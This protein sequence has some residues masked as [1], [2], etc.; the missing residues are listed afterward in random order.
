MRPWSVITR[1]RPTQASRPCSSTQGIECRCRCK[2]RCVCDTARL[3]LDL[4]LSDPPRLQHVSSLHHHPAAPHHC[5]TPPPAPSH[6][7]LIAER[8]L[9]G[10]A[11]CS[12]CYARA[13]SMPHLSTCSTFSA[14]RIRVSVRGFAG[15]H[16]QHH[17]HR[18]LPARA[19]Q[20]FLLQGTKAPLSPSSLKLDPT[21]PASSFV[22]PW[23]LLTYTCLPLPYSY[24]STLPPHHRRATARCCC[25]ITMHCC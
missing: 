11:P 6:A 19:R 9:S 5:S 10:C 7:L 14:T 1:P 15:Q 13:V 3:C 23:L 4:S 18:F 16:L 20:V 12:T 17:Q 21:T 22:F 25:V 24:S 8:L 2:C